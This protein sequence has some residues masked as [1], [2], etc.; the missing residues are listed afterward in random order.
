MEAEIAVVDPLCVEMDLQDLRRMEVVKARS[1]TCGHVVM[2]FFKRGVRRER[3][4][5]CV[6][7]GENSRDACL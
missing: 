6:L 7:R 1:R 5:A 2:L 3:R 4:E